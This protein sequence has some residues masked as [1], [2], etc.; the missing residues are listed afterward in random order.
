M[1]LVLLV[2]VLMVIGKF[3][4][5]ELL[6]DLMVLKLI[7]MS[8]LMFHNVTKVSKI[9]MLL[10]SVD[11]VTL[12]EICSLLKVK[13]TVLNGLQDPSTFQEVKKLPFMIP[14]NLLDKM[15]PLLQV[16]LNVLM[17]LIL[18]C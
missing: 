4:V 7:L 10:Y 9:W 5:V 18:T 12:P 15:L 16:M 6:P 2:G 13:L 11:L 3:L 17:K 1:L 8:I 14:V